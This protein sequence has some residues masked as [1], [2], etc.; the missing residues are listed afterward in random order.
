ML[1]FNSGNFVLA[2]INLNDKKMREI[3][4]DIKIRHI[5]TGNTFREVLT[6]DEIMTSGKLYT[7]G[8]QEVVFKRQFTGFLDLDVERKEIYVSDILSKRWKVEVYQNDEGTFMVKFHNNQKVNKPTT[9]KKYLL[10]R[11]K[12]G[13]ADMDC[14]VIGNIY[15]NPELLS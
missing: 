6:L 5:E 7:K 10:R 2:S 15:E 1:T 14:I 13:T 11:E 4:F 12:A 3:K 8:I 9:L